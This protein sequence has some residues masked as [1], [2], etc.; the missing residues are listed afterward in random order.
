MNGESLMPRFRRLG[1]YCRLGVND[2][3]S[4]EGGVAEAYDIG[5]CGHT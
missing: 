3:E 2:R 4:P 5:R 1:S